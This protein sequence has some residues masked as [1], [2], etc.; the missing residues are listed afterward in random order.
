[1]I[2]EKFVRGTLKGLL[3]ARGN[4]SGSIPIFSRRNNINEARGAKTFEIILPA[5]TADGT[6]SEEAQKRVVDQFLGRSAKKEAPP[7]EKVFDFSVARKIFAQLQA[8]G[9]RPESN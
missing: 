4:R 7:L 6:M 1:M 5:M 8:Q 2:I 3:Y 9:W